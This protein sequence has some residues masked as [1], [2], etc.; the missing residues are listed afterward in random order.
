MRIGR[1]AE[2]VL[3]LLS[4]YAKA[5]GT[6]VFVRQLV[7]VRE[8]KRRLRDLDG[9]N[10]RRTIGRLRRAGYLAK[11]GDGIALSSRGRQEILKRCLGIERLASP[12]RW[13]GRWRL[14]V[15]DVPDVRRGRRGALRRALSAL[16]L[17]LLQKSVWVHPAPCERQVAKIVAGLGVNRYV[18]FVVAELVNDDRAMRKKFG[19]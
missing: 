17:E 5:G 2:A 15:F 19:L 16:G 4:A 14:V 12:A 1:V 6:Q 10:A 7:A 8:L 3:L 18:A 13:D 9:S 11:R